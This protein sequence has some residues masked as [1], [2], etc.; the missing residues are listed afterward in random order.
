MKNLKTKI[1]G[2]S[3]KNIESL[4]FQAKH[5]YEALA[6]AI[7]TEEHMDAAYSAASYQELWN[8]IRSLSEQDVSIHLQRS[9]DLAR[10]LDS[11]LV[12]YAIGIELS[13]ALSH[14]TSNEPLQQQATESD[15]RLK[16]QDMEEL[17][18]KSEIMYDAISG[19]ASRMSKA[20]K[21]SD[22]L[23]AINY[24]RDNYKRPYFPREVL[25]MPI[26]TSKL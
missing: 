12:Q 3:E 11:F 9:S 19:L 18:G 4:E 10:L 25:V 16:F 14:A 22:L 21:Y 1:S 2:I 26:E 6:M 5:A 15:Q 17:I 23:Q 7:D 8:S 13:R 20:K 24:V